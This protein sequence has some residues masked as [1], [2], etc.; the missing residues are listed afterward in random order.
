MCVLLQ[1]LPQLPDIITLIETRKLSWFPEIPGYKFFYNYGE[2]NV[3]DGVIIYIKNDI[4]AENE[5][6]L[7][8]TIKVLKT[9]ITINNTKL[10][11]TS[12]YRSH[13]VD[14]TDFIKG[15]REYLNKYKKCDTH[16]VLGDFNINILDDNNIVDQYLDTFCSRGFNSY[17]NT[18]TRPGETGGTCID[19]MFYKCN[20]IAAKAAFLEYRITDHFPIIFNMN[21]VN[22][23][24]LENNKYE[25]VSYKK[26][27]KVCKTVKWGDIYYIN[28]VD[29][30]TIWLVNKIKDVIDQSTI[31]RKKVKGKNK[32]RKIWITYELIKLCELKKKK[33]IQLKKNP[34]IM[35]N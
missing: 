22:V 24:G 18:V 27:H 31:K 16:L 7:I 17:I 3:C 34:N 1:L 2:I 14:E 29:E 21:V 6:I 30:A 8:N 35:K 33:Y 12:V 5:V 4:Q 19:H 9:I 13:E 26:L 15:L 25:Y 11:I 32:P 28:K 10:M 23:N 20:S